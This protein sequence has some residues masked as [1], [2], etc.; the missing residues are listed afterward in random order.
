MIINANA[1]DQSV[2]TEKSSNCRPLPCPAA[3]Y[4]VHKLLPLNNCNRSIDRHVIVA[5][6]FRPA[7]VVWLD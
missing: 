5:A 2:A 4:T 3:D 6:A 7:A 1:L